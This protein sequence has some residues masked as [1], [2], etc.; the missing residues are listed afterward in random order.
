MRQQPTPAQKLDSVQHAERPSH[1]TI[2]LHQHLLRLYN[3]S[4][5]IGYTIVPESVSIVKAT[6]PT[7]DKQC[8]SKEKREKS[9]Q[10]VLFR[11]CSDPVLVPYFDELYQALE[12]SAVTSG[13]K[14]WHTLLRWA[15][16]SSVVRIGATAN[17]RRSQD[18]GFSL[19]LEAGRSP[20]AV[21]L[22]MTHFE[23]FLYNS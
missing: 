20:T 13:G 6:A 15:L 7:N 18:S 8:D 23:H 16:R 2:H 3:I 17:G 1:A 9:V 5:T 19:R 10:R 11:F 12:R 22:P 4:I 14:E 21:F